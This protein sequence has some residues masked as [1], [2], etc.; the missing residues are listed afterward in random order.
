MPSSTEPQQVSRPSVGMDA[1]LSNMERMAGQDRV[2]IA[3]LQARVAEL[4]AENKQLNQDNRDMHLSLQQ[5]NQLLRE[6]Q[7][8]LKAMEENV[9]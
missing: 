8:A 6:T 7:Q 2:G 1:V 5:A 3:M 9:G 4:E